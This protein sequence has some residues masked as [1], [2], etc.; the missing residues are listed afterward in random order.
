MIKDGS[1][2][3]KC[4]CTICSLRTGDLFGDFLKRNLSSKAS[5]LGR[6][7]VSFMEYAVS[8]GKNTNQKLTCFHKNNLQSGVK[9]RS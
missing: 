3:P 5:V 6:A 2:S 7:G 9:E 8:D 1:S 4:S